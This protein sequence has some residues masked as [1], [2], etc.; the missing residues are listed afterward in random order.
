MANLAGHVCAGHGQ[1]GSQGRLRGRGGCGTDQLVAVASALVRSWW[2]QDTAT[3][4]GRRGAFRAK[5]PTRLASRCPD[6][7]PHPQLLSPDGMKTRADCSPP[8]AVPC[9]F[10]RGRCEQGTEDARGSWT[11]AG[12]LLAGTRISYT[13]PCRAFTRRQGPSTTVSISIQ[14]SGCSHLCHMNNICRVV[15]VTLRYRSTANSVKLPFFIT[16]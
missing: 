14:Q 9:D 13:H 11:G 4:T 12:N 7:A 5:G 15:R 8:T 16:C 1:L 6:A 3:R 2:Q 10:L